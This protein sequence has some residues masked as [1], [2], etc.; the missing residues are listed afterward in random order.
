MNFLIQVIAFIITIL[1]LVSFHEAGHFCVAKL[2]GVKVLRFS[3]GFGK[4]IYRHL[5][6]TGTE[7]IIA[8]IPLGGYVKLLDERETVV[9]ESEKHL[10]F[11]HQPLWVK[12]AIV[13]AGPLTNIIFAIFGFWLMLILGVQTLRPIAG[14]IAPNSIAAKAGMQTG[15][16]I[17][18]VDGRSTPSWQKVMFRLIDRV[19]ETGYLIFNTKNIY[20]QQV[21]TYDLNLEHW[22]INPLNPDPLSSLGIQPL[23]PPLP[24]ILEAVDYGSPAANAGLQPH[25]KILTIADHTVRDWY[26]LVKYLR[27]H[28]GQ[29]ATVQYLRDHKSRSTTLT[30][31]RKLSGFHWI[32]YI[33]VKTKSVVTPPYML[34]MR[35]SSLLAALPEAGSETWHFLVFNFVVVKKMILGQISLSSLGGP[36]SILK[37]AD[38]ALRQGFAIFFGFLALISV[39]LAFINIL[40]IPGLDGGHLLNYLIEFIIRRPLS[41]TYQILS[42]RIGMFL[43]LLLIAF[44]TI[45]DILRLFSSTP[46]R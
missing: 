42:I 34:R 41:L 18:M 3:I 36:I 15:D 30:I 16:E 39:M 9:P 5:G 28:P 23:Q 44:A 29:I 40:P 12:T 35:Q 11:N 21:H 24:A 46:V 2:L 22:N 33:G 27:A 7:Y 20:T 6:K 1:I 10:E 45:N 43:L 31:E 25:D 4:S 38:Q 14:N 37:V 32:G 13:L 26:D 8:L 19:G 17:N